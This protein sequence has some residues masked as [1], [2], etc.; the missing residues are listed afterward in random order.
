MIEHIRTYLQQSITDIIYIGFR[1][2]QPDTCITLYQT[3]GLPPDA[4]HQYNSI[5]I[6]VSTRAKK[7]TDAYNLAYAVFNKLQSLSTQT[8]NG[9][10]I[11][12]IQADQDPYSLGQDEIN[13]FLFTQNFIMSYYMELENRI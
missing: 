7:Y 4:K 2:A 3:S 5:G 11:V 10:F 9:T 1:A 12:D 8:I 13:R 6:Q